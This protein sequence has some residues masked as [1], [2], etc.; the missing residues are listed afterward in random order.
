M[1][2]VAPATLMKRP[3]VIGTNETLREAA[4]MK[5]RPW[6]R[7]EFK[8]RRIFYAFAGERPLMKRSASNFSA[9]FH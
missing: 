1:K 9:A 3:E 5:T 8:A 6:G 2:R 4:L 7:L